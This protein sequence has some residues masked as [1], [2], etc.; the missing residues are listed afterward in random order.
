LFV[1]GRKGK[2]RKEREGKWDEVGWWRGDT[3]GNGSSAT[4]YGMQMHS[5]MKS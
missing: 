5:Q 2:E 1:V 4:S 3:R